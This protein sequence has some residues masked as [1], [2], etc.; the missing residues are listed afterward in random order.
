MAKADNWRTWFAAGALWLGACGS[1]CAQTVLAD[2]APL[3]GIQ[4]KAPPSGSL[5]GRLTDLQSAPLAGV[6]VIL[7]NQAT[8]IDVR[9]VT[10]KNG[11]FRLARLEAGEYT[12][13]ADEPRLGHGRLEGILVTG[14]MEARVQAALRFEPLA[15]EL[16]SKELAEAAAEPGEIAVPQPTAAAMP[17]MAHATPVAA[18]LAVTT[19]APNSSATPVAASSPVLAPRPTSSVPGPS[20]PDSIAYISLAPDSRAHVSVVPVS[21]VSVSRV[22]AAAPVSPP[23]TDSRATLSTANPEII[24]MVGA[25]PLRAMHPTPRD[26]GAVRPPRELAAAQPVIP[27]F[28][29]PQPQVPQPETPRPTPVRAQGWTAPAPLPS[30]QLR[31]TLDTQSITIEAALAN[32]LPR[33]FSLTHNVTPALVPLNMAAASG[34]NA[35]LLLGQTALT[36]V[37]AAAQRLDPAAT[38]VATTVTATQLESL[39]AGGRRWQEFLLDTPAASTGPD[40]TQASYRGSQESAEITI[41]G[42]STTLKFGA[43]ACSGYPSASQDPAGQ[44]ANQPSAMSQAM[45][46]FGTGGHGLGVSEAAVHEVTAVSGNV[47]A[48]GM[49][50]AGGRTSIETERGGDALHGQGFFYDRQNNWGARNPFTQWVTETSEAAPLAP[51]NT[52]QFPVF[53]NGPTGAPESYTP[54]DHEVVWGIGMGSSLRRDKLFWFAAL[55]SYHRNDPG[56]AMVKHPYLEQTPTGCGTTSGCTPTT[57]GFFATPSD[58][59]LTLLSAQLALPSVNP[60]VEGLTAYSCMLETLAGMPSGSSPNCPAGWPL[61]GLLG[62]A[63]RSA[64]QWVGFA[65]IDWQAAERHRFTVEGIGADWSSPGGGLT[66]VSENDGNRSFGSSYASQEWLLARWEAY[67][68]PNLLAVTQGSAG[69]TILSAG[70][71]R[72]RISRRHFSPSIPMASCRRSSWIRA[73]VL[74]SAILRGSARAATPT[75]VSTTRRNRWTGCTITCWSRRDSSSITIMTRPAFCAIKRAR[76]PI[77][78]CK[79]LS[80]MRWFLRSTE[81]PMR[82]MRRIRTTAARRRPVSAAS[83]A[84]LRIRKR[85]ARPTGT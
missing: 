54:P 22:A 18:T 79:T 49:R 61:S 48:E 51:Y 50:S 15:P 4:I 65:R 1:V 40:A 23:A 2:P 38:I 46:G 81:L 26:A 73:T 37:A 52:A 62:P 72:R 34:I 43:A 44:E 57:T 59:Q 16:R 8:G 64:A 30:P 66:R 17:L 76:I 29:A 35:A 33:T 71:A 75:N 85:W 39:P 47:E 60:E 67:L 31:A 27:N 80:P 83:P 10:G 28:V 77:R 36:P 6:S 42:A 78:R 14:G 45:S 24:A 21:R 3:Q 13:E 56:L 25:E 20:V 19:F 68:T 41:D 53:D 84:T 69:R 12:L 70:P 82:S 11:A 5:A 32:T 74:R 58:A 63:P 7:H 9:V 55:D